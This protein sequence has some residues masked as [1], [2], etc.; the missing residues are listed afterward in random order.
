MSR[1][2]RNILHP[3]AATTA[4]GTAVL[5]FVG[6]LVTSTGSGLAVPDWPLSFG[7][8][9]P[10]MEGGVLYEHGHRMVAGVILLLTL[11]LAVTV[12]LRDPRRAVR[13]LAWGAVAVVLLQALLGG[14]T[15]LLRLPLAVSVFHA[16]L[17]Q[18]F[19][20]LVVTLAVVTSPNWPGL[21]RPVPRSPLLFLS[22]ATVTLVFGQ[23]V[24]GALVRHMGAG[25]AIPDF[26]LSFG[27]WIPPVFP[28]PVLVHFLHRLGAVAVTLAVVLTAAQALRLRALA[29]RVARAALVLV[30]L[31]AG[32]LALGAA[33][34]WSRRAVLPTTA[35]VLL[36]ALVL[37][38]SVVL[39]LRS[40][41][42]A[43]GTGRGGHEP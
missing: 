6:G 30:S 15:V 28:E 34:V 16:C 9:F 41:S 43:P 17:A 11:A 37:A 13:R 31:V 36:G 40:A 14:A 29:P 38:T 10:P 21:A 24:L 33:I 39:V 2:S 20:C 23:L 3:L 19:L 26:P 18:I 42:L 32:Q 8:L 27:R 12:Q 1:G 7:T 25:L 35:H 22:G 5:I 4:A